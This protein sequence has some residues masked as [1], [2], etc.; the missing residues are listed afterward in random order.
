MTSKW[1]EEEENILRKK[2]SNTSWKDILK[3]LPNRSKNGIT[4]KAYKMGLNREVFSTKEGTYFVY[5][6]CDRHGRILHTEVLWS[7]RGNRLVPI[8][9]RPFC[10][11]ELRILPK[12]SKWR[13]KYREVEKDE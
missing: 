6:T 4:Q 13:A 9:P 2:Y 7:K 12:H 8:C 3:L 5:A 11:R 1:T 10:N